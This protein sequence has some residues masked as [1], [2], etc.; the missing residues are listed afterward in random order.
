[1]NKDQ[2]KQVLGYLDA[3]YAGI[4]SRMSPEDRNIRLQHWAKEVG[5]L[6]FGMTMTA[7]RKLSRGPYMPRTGEVIAEVERQKESVRPKQKS[8]CRIFRD[9]DGLEIVDLRYSDGSEWVT[10]YLAS[11]PE[12]MQKKFRWMANPTQEN[13]EAWDEV[14]ASYES[15]MEVA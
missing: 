1:M 15:A 6:D 13:V 7:V 14:I 11:F 2:L 12:W 3:E 4:T 8:K 9:A 5:P 10:G